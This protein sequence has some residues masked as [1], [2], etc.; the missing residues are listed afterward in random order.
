VGLSPR[1]PR[2]DITMYE[3]FRTQRCLKRP[4]NR[5]VINKKRNTEL[6]LQTPEFEFKKN[7]TKLTGNG[8]SCDASPR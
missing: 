7:N 1:V 3:I 5:N 8:N 2:S 4:R 6:N